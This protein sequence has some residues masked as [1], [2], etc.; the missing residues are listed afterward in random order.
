MQHRNFVSGSRSVTMRIKSLFQRLHSGHAYPLVHLYKLFQSILNIQSL[1][2]YCMGVFT[3]SG[4]LDNSS[5]MAVHC[6]NE[7]FPN[8]NL[9]YKI[10]I[11]I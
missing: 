11:I 9:C 5:Q 1:L 2:S 3:F 10:Q 8:K 7:E 4:T 6:V